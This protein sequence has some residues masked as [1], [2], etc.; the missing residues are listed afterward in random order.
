ML[1]LLAF[2]V[3]NLPTRVITIYMLNVNYSVAM[4]L[5]MGLAICAYVS[6][7]LQST[8]NPI[9][10]SMMAKKWRQDLKC[11][12]RNSGNRLTMFIRRTNVL[13]FNF[14]EVRTT[15]V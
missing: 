8:L 7:P 5:Y 1:T 4:D 14:A 6:Y 2:V 12:A 13:D 10:Y 11:V 9:L 3:C 15:N